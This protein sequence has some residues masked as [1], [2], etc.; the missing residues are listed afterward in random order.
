MIKLIDVR[1]NGESE[2]EELSAMIQLMMISVP[3][4]MLIQVFDSFDAGNN[5]QQRNSESKNRLPQNE[6]RHWIQ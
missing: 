1:E 5:L 3:D 2:Y 6:D 4:Q